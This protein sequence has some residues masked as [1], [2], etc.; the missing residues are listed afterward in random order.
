MFAI[1]VPLCAQHRPGYASFGQFE[2]NKKYTGTSHNRID[3]IV[4]ATLHQQGIRPAKLCSDAV[5]IRRVYL[6]VIGTLPEPPEIRKFLEKRRPDK[7]AT[8]INTL[9]CR[10][11]VAE[12]VRPASGQGG[13]SHKSVAQRG[14]GISSLDSRLPAGKYALRQICP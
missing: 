2:S 7:R 9:L 11:L 14:A 6:D 5:F 10:L 1:C 12:V 4:M 8:L 13:I 3:T